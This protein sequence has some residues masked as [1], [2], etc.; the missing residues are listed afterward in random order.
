MAASSVC[1]RCSCRMKYSMVAGIVA[2]RECSFEGS[3]AR[4]P[5]LVPLTVMS[6]L[7]PCGAGRSLLVCRG[8]QELFP[9]ARITRTR[10]LNRAFSQGARHTD[11][12]GMSFSMSWMVVDPHLTAAERERFFAQPAKSVRLTGLV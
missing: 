4:V 7:S 8:P 9:A 2:R 5:H 3:P 6:D 1:S 10:I 12:D 11:R